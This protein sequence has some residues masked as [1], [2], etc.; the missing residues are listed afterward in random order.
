[1][2]YFLDIIIYNID[3]LFFINIFKN[4]YIYYFNLI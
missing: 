2:I 1:M 3:I 4:I